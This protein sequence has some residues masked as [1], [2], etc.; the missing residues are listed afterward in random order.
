MRGIDVDDAA[1]CHDV[2]KKHSEECGSDLKGVS[3][4]DLPVMLD[5]H[6]A[7]PREVTGLGRS[8]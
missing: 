3:P 1:L 8:L 6:T 7:G 4:D 5:E 2:P